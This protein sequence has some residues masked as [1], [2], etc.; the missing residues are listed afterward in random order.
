MDEPTSS[1]LHPGDFVVAGQTLGEPTALIHHL[2]TGVDP[3]PEMRLFGGMSLTGVFAKAPPNVALSTFI[4]TGR[5]A[6]LIASG[7]MSVVPCHMSD[8]PWGLRDG[9]LRPDV[10]LVLVSPPDADGRCSL[11][12]TSDFIAPAVSCARVV[13]AEINQQVPRVAGDTTV[14]FE[15][16]GAAVHTDRPL[17]EFP[18]VAPTDVERAIARQ[19]ASFIPDGSCLQIGVGRLGEAV[20]ETVSD[21]RHLGVHS[22]MVGD[23]ILEMAAAGIITNLWKGIDTGLTVTGSVLGSKRAVELAGGNDRLRLRSVDYTHDPAV[24]KRL[25]N[26]VCVNSAIEVDLLGQVNSEIT[27]GR[28]LGGIGGAVDF[29]RGSVGAG[30][31][32]IVALPATARRGAVSRVVPSVQ[33][34]TALRSDVDLVATERGVA[35]LR[36]V[37]EGERAARLIELAAPAHQE[38]LRAAAKNMGL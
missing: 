11:G 6:E 35:D 19:L 34:V 16:I 25:D 28:Y 13:L 21:R 4:G 3:L 12:L 38:E 32:S 27:D 5:N 14:P 37:S 1:L 9:P 29:L 17:P 23:T 8:L 33:R 18:R 36:G 26:V 20:L 30:G 24:I 2:F 31:R 10:A 7:R 22:G 15:R